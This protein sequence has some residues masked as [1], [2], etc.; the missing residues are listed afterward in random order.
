ME[1]VL[2]TVTH[3]HSRKRVD[4]WTLASAL[5]AL[6]VATPILVIVASLATPTT[7]I[8]IHLWQT[9]LA[10]LLW[11]TFRLILGVG[12]G[13]LVLGTGLAWLV[14]MYRFPGRAIF[15]WLLILPLAIPTYVIGFVFLALFDYTGPIQSWLR[16]AIG[17]GFWFPEIASYGGVTVVMTLVLYPY[18][19][20]LARAAFSEQSPGK[21]E[22]ARSLGANSLGLFWKV[23][24]PLARPS[25][26]AGLAFALMEAL[27]D[28][29]TVVI[30]GYSTFTVAIYRIWFGMF[31]RHAATEL[32][33]LL[34]LFTL[35]LYLLERTGRGRARFY[36][37]DG[38]ARPV[39]AKTLQGWKAWAATITV[40][41]VVGVA[42]VLPVG[43]LF[44]WVLTH[45]SY[46][47]RYPEFLFN[48]LTLG[49]LTALLAVAAAVIVAYG[50]RLS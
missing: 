29:G 8:W 14:T 27:A 47:T 45:H 43:Q 13:T 16:G 23:A 41:L 37:T 6:I 17:A 10:E 46:D 44:A 50:Q 11:N 35:A 32:A 38:T 2:T 33:S 7:D 28:F 42:F 1:K 25:I 12:L 20:V 36:R 3:S 30:F 15:D 18:V 21:L 39:P 48:S 34:M 4:P 31:N 40:S 49:I 22:A 24:L 9:Q 19:Y 26:A 5:V